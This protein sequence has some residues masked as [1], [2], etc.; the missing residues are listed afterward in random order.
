MDICKQIDD[1][2]WGESESVWNDTFSLLM[3]NEN[4]RNSLVNVVMKWNLRMLAEYESRHAKILDILDGMTC[5]KEGVRKLEMHYTRII[6]RFKSVHSC[7]TTIR[8]LMF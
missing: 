8:E 4:G 5:E 1:I 6:S 7:C 2:V 3:L